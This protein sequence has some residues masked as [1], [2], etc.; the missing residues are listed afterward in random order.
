MERRIEPTEGIE[1]IV[2]GRGNVAIISIG[3]G[4]VIELQRGTEHKVAQWILECQEEANELEEG[5]E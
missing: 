2:N 3:E 4:L 1:V 5:Q